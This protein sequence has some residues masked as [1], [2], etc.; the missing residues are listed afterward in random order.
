MRGLFALLAAGGIALV[1]GLI[2]YQVGLAQ[3]VAATTGSV[4][5]MG[6]FGWGFPFFGF[7]FFFL[8][9]GF[10]AFAFGGARRRGWGPGS[11]GPGH[12]SYGGPGAWSGDDSRRQWIA[13]AHRRLHE[14]EAKAA[15][16]TTPTPTDRPT[17]G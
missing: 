16:T 4:V 3:T 10:L 8:F 7:I 2:G 17:A 15:A 11:Y 6:G 5:W 14:E 1:A 13:D 12:G 9:I